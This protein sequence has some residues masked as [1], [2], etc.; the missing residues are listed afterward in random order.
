METTANAATPG[1]MTG[2]RRA[3]KHYNV[4]DF[5]CFLGQTDNNDIIEAVEI[6]DRRCFDP[7]GQPKAFSR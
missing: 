3:Q 2:I 6:R 1:L 4:D 5:F 7:H